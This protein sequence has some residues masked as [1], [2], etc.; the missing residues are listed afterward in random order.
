MSVPPK[1]VLGPVLVEAVRAVVREEVD[2][3]MA[4]YRQREREPKWL[5]L[6]EAAEYARCS[7][8]AITR[9]LDRGLIEQGYVGTRRLVRRESLDAYVRGDDEGR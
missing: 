1:E 4:H 6:D 7:K 3:L 8:R 2:R 5:T 9:R